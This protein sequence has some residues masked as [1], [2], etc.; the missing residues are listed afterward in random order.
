MLT[1]GLRYYLRILLRLLFRCD[2]IWLF[3]L[4][5]CSKTR[6]FNYFTKLI[7][8]Y[9]VVLVA[10]CSCGWGLGC[11]F[12]HGGI[13]KRWVFKYYNVLHIYRD[14]MVQHY[15]SG[16]HMVCDIAC[17]LNTQFGE[18]VT[19]IVNF[20]KIHFNK[21]NNSNS[22]RALL[23]QYDTYI[24]SLYLQFNWTLC[25]MCRFGKYCSDEC[26]TQIIDVLDAFT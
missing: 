3:D 25:D 21:S 11:F 17:P 4:N 24:R 20:D 7:V 16:C 19:R 12:R 9:F 14:I 23:F 26:K 18:S 13:G 6:N 5:I 22:L 15:H 2:I 8:L 1:L 10:A